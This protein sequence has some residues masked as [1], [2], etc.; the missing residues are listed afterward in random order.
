M[1]DDIPE[2]HKAKTCMLTE[3]LYKPYLISIL[4]METNIP[5]Q[6]LRHTED[7]SVLIYDNANMSSAEKD[8]LVQLLSKCASTLAARPALS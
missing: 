6:S 7:C 1:T 2:T 8:S 3:N 5:D 4:N